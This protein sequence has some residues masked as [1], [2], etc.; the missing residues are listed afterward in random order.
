MLNLTGA[1]VRNGA[2][3]E[4]GSGGVQSGDVGKNGG[5]VTKNG[6][7]TRNGT[8]ST[9][10]NSGSPRMTGTDGVPSRLADGESVSMSEG[11]GTAPACARPADLIG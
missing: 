6:T 4:H 1:L 11:I 5:G 8:E 7:A 2:K 9:G 3:C 10:L